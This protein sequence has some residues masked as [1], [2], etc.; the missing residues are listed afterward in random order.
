MVTVPPPVPAIPELESTPTRAL[1][2]AT[3][4][5]AVTAGVKDVQAWAEA[6]GASAWAGDTQEAADHALTVFGRRLAGPE[7][8]LLRAATAADRFEDRLRR[9]AGRRDG[10]RRR[11]AALNDA[12][13]ALDREI[14]TAVGDP[15]PATVDDWQDR[16]DRLAE[17]RRRLV[18]D[19]AA[20]SADE[21]AAAADFIAALA[22]VDSA[23]EGDVAAQD[24]ARPD[25][26]EL[27]RTLRRLL[28]DPV[29]LRNW[30]RTLTRA[31]RQGL[32]TEHPGIVGNADGVPVRDRDEANRTGLYSD[33]DHLG[34]RERDGQL[35]DAQRDLLANAT[36]IRDELSPFAT[37]IDAGTGDHLTNLIVY[38][39]GEHTGDGGVAVGLGD[40]DRADHVAVAVP[41]FTN[42]TSSLGDNLDR[43]HALYDTASA[44]QN[45]TVAAVTWLDYDAPSGGLGGLDDIKDLAKVASDHEA[46]KG[47]DQLKGF[48]DG[49][50]ASDEGP[51]AHLT[52]IGHSYGSTVV[53][54]AVHAGAP[55]DDVV[56]L[57]SP[58]QP[59]AT[60]TELTDAD[61]WVGSKDYDPISLL[62]SGDRGGIGALG[63]DPA[64]DDFGGTRFDTGKGSYQVQDLLANHS[65]YYKGTSL[66]NVGAIVAGHDDQ[67]TTQPGR[68]GYGD[69]RYQT[70]DE[71]LAG[72][73]VVGGG[74]WVGDRAVDVGQWLKENSVQWGGLR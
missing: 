64:Q 26:P 7:A 10:L 56:L 31:Q 4:L 14:E 72:S 13:A 2:L 47:G 57:G 52:A 24:P 40:P 36:T 35:T 3:N 43:T 27:D 63:H 6:R 11:R 62:G 33:L 45:G 9:L 42:D 18:G 55:V 39:P 37:S 20:W 66:Q 15:D 32:M 12:I 69:G 58:G 21:D 19:I 23:A 73:S 41:G 30:W 65:S 54:H 1:T 44:E 17:R 28:G 49:L 22:E 68:D 53:G 5:R 34:E 48:L 38:Q 16:A 50:R 59:A 29:A 70:L 60:A 25:L 74:S 8:A 71:L 51:T 61:V 67:V 46:A